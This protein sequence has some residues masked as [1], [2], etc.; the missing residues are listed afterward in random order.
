MTRYDN[1]WRC[2]NIQGKYSI[3]YDVVISI[4]SDFDIDDST[5]ED[6]YYPDYLGRKKAKK[7]NHS[8]MKCTTQTNDQWK[9]PPYWRGNF[10]FLILWQ[11]WFMY[12]GH[13]FLK[14]HLDW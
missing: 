7:C 1:E 2:T 8:N 10:L 5:E 4:S 14:A 12:R 13:S 6:D 3:S 9:T 11:L